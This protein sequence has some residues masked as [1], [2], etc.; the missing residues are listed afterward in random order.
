MDLRTS[1]STSVSV[2]IR[3]R[4]T[5]PYGVYAR[6][7]PFYFDFTGQFGLQIYD[8]GMVLV[9]IKRTLNSEFIPVSLAVITS[10]NDEKSSNELHLCV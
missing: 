2:L 9:V 6:R 5:P 8:L 7:P 10:G 3:I 4:P 1:A